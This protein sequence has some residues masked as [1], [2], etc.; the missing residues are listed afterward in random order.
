M[1]A[2][3]KPNDTVMTTMFAAGA[4]TAPFIMQGADRLVRHPAAYAKLRAALDQ[5]RAEGEAEWVFDPRPR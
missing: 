5:K 2:N 3:N 4:D 1:T